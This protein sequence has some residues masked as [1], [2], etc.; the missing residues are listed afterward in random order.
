MS[1]TTSIVRFPRS[2][3]RR[4]ASAAPEAPSDSLTDSEIALLQQAVE[5]RYACVAVPIKEAPVRKRVDGKTVW[6]GLVEILELVDHPKAIRAYA[7]FSS[8]EES[9]A[10][11]TIATILHSPQISS[12]KKAVHLAAPESAAER[13]SD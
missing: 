1:E 13:A 5:R 7:W 3:F 4:N 12:A 9:P 10:A 2:V 6:E 11:R 8:D